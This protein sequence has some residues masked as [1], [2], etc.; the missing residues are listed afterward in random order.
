M[1]S[2]LALGVLTTQTRTGVIAVI[3]AACLDTGA[4]RV[5]DTLWFAFSVGVT[6][7]AG[8]TRALTL[9]SHL[10]GDGPGAAGVGAAWVSYNG[11]S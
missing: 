1:V 8:G 11:L 7:Q 10:P 9:I 6:K 5:Y 2:D 4:V 3:V